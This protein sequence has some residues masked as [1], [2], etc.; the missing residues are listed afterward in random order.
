TGMC[1]GCRASV[2]GKTVFVCVDGPE[3]DAHEVDFDLLTTRT[4]FYGTQEKNALHEF[5]CHNER[6]W[7]EAKETEGQEA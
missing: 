7:R 5:E 3:F 4:K 2:G 1:G 6:R